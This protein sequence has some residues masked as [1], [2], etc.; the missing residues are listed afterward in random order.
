MKTNEHKLTDIDP[1]QNYQG[2]L[3]WSNASSPQVYQN[4]QLPEW[5]DEK[6]NPFIVE[7]Q[8]YN[9]SN[10]KSYSIRFVDGNYLINF[11]DLNEL[12]EFEFIDKKYLP[13]RFPDGIQ[14]LCF[15]EFWRPVKDKLCGS[16]I[17][18]ENEKEFEGMD[19]LQ[20]AEVV[21]VGFNY[22]ED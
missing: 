12:K 6:V 2:Y 14:K 17:G 1:G 11:F 7:G 8:L 5:P 16:K 21:F 22:K 13:N 18:E 19:V 3:W 4:Q 9:K 10:N 20:P 15:K